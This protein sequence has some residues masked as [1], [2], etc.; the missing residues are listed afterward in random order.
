MRE[1]LDW[2]MTGPAWVRYHCLIDLQDTNEEAQAAQTT[3]KEMLSDPQILKLIADLNEWET[4]PLKRHND[5]I[6][7]L[8]KLV[9]LADIGLKAHDDGLSTILSVIKNH[10]SKDGPFQVISNYP[11]VFGGSGRDEWLW[12]ACDAPS[13]VYALQKMGMENGL[14]VLSATDFLANSGRDNGWPCKADSQLGN[15]K[16]PGRQSD[17][18]PYANLIMLKLLAACPEKKKYQPKIQAGLETALSLWEY[19]HEQRPYLFKMGTD[20]RKLKVPFIW[21]DLLHLAET[22]SYYPQVYNDARFIEILSILES[23]QDESGRFTSESIWTK[24]KGWEFCQKQE[25]S[26]WVTLCALRILK[27][28]GRWSPNSIPAG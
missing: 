15:F 5:A 24:W 18:C 10:Q 26:R 6:H 3:K 2:L 28:T 20:F 23:K 1:V 21:Y 4:T 22:L 7:P 17:P 11:T 19:S 12:C 14:Q 8:H 9:F 25:P 27:R 16:G 13:T